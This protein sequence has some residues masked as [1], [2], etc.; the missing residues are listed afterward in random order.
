MHTIFQVKSYLFVSVQEQIDKTLPEILY[1]NPFFM[2]AIITIVLISAGF[3]A[4]VG[5]TEIGRYR[6]FALMV[7]LYSRLKG[8]KILSHSLREEIYNHIKKYPGDH[9]RS[10]M[11]K[12]NLKNGTLVHH[13]S[14][15]EQEELIKSQK[16]GL[17]KRFYPIGMKIP[18]SDVGMY[19]PDGTITYNISDK[20]VSEIQ[21]NILK[22]INN[23]PGC[24][25]K[26]ISE[27]INESRR[28]VNYH[29]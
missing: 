1:A 14:R 10:I 23:K 13:L 12:L 2:T 8:T 3:G 7:P 26:D 5:G 19:Y 21:M 22:A 17:Y 27:I 28:V 6:F 15:L 4:A 29:I 16:D 20:Q 18:Q 9:Y 11:N 25:Q 24:T